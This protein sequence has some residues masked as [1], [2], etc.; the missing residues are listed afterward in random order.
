VH[1]LE[2][3]QCELARLF[4]SE[5]GDETDKF[6][7]CTWHAGPDEL[8][9]LDDAAGWFTGAVLS[10]YDLGDHVGFLLEPVE[11]SAPDEFEQLVTFSDVRDLEPGHEA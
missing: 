3:R 10:R 11:G 4:G 6:A 2:R 5:T 8:P 1:V 9:I 7:Q